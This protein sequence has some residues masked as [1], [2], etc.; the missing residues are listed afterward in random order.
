META[1]NTT[2]SIKV[3]VPYYGHLSLPPAG[4]STIY[5]IVSVDPCSK[6]ASDCMLSV[7]NTKLEPSLPDW[8]KKLGVNGLICSD[9]GSQHQTPLESQKI[10][11]LWRQEGD[12]VELVNRWAAGHL[13]DPSAWRCGIPTNQWCSAAYKQ[14]ES[15]SNSTKKY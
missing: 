2:E 1:C 3:A 10:W 8:L 15:L 6:K 4:L 9:K 11:T 7:W 13:S 12:A 5:F 14:Q